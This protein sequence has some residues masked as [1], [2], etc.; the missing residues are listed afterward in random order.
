MQPAVAR[1]GEV[2]GPNSSVRFHTKEPDMTVS[3]TTEEPKVNWVVIDVNALPAEAAKLF[4]EQKALY[5][6]YVEGKLR[7]QNQMIKDADLGEGETLAFNFKFGN[8]SYGVVPVKTATKT[9][10]KAVSFA[11]SIAA[12]KAKVAAAAATEAP[13]LI[14]KVA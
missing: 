4:V 14:K 7:W 8:T 10:R 6:A 13:R 1:R 12:H 9:S 2:A 5:H 3:S 11:E